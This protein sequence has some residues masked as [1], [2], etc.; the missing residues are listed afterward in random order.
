MFV[1]LTPLHSNCNFDP[2]SEEWSGLLQY[3]PRDSELPILFKILPDFVVEVFKVT[4]PSQLRPTV[5]ELN[6]DE[7]PV[8]RPTQNV[9]PVAHL[10]AN[11]SI[12]HSH[13]KWG[14]VEWQ[15]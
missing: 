15:T 4:R 5:I 10:F 7:M 3:V 13:A 9:S 14:S 12:L 2:E 6:E 8:S 11:N 1:R